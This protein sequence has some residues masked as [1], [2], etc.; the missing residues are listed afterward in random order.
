MTNTCTIVKGCCRP[1]AQKEYKYRGKTY[2]IC[3]M[4]LAR[5]RRGSPVGAAKG[6]PV[7]V[8]K[9]VNRNSA[10]ALLDLI[11]KTKR[12]TWPNC[13]CVRIDGAAFYQVPHKRR[14]SVVE[15]IAVPRMVAWTSRGWVRISLDADGDGL[16]IV[17]T[18]AGREAIREAR[19]GLR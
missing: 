6:R 10:R 1:W 7:G 2:R 13:H 16:R 14:T 9:R 5:I 18:K 15:N 17:L 19:R 4:H 11:D 3:H 8:S 12:T